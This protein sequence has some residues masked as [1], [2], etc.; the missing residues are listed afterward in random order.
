MRNEPLFEYIARC[1]VCADTHVSIS[2]QGRIERCPLLRVQPHNQPGPAAH[3]FGRA[4]L[5][6][7]AAR[8]P[9]NAKAF[10]L[11]RFLTRFSS[12]VPCERS[13]L[14]RVHFDYSV[15]KLRNLHSTVEVLRREWL[16]PVGSRKDVPSGYWIITELDDFSRWVSRARSAPIT[17]LTTIHR[18][19]KAN[20]PLFA[21]QLE[22][23]FWRDLS[24]SPPYQGGVAA[25]SADGVVLLDK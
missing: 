11:A 21:E 20:F 16:L 19:A 14:I 17:Q 1:I 4:A 12:A 7:A 10:D 3:V 2:P 9:V 8:G 15:H 23:D 13:E 18:V 24:D 5:R 25:A 6:V 22:L